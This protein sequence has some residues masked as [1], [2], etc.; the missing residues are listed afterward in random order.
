METR[1]TLTEGNIKMLMESQQSLDGHIRDDLGITDSQWKFNLETNHHLALEIEKA[2]FINECFD[3]WKYWKRKPVTME[4]ILDEAVDV[5]HFCFI[6]IN[7]DMLGK[8]GAEKTIKRQM[9]NYIKWYAG[10]NLKAEPLISTHPHIFMLNY[11]NENNASP[12]Q[13][14][15]KT[16]MILNR[17]GFLNEHVIAQ[18]EIKNGVNHERIEQGY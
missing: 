12:I 4:K 2:E 9:D 15:A 5:I 11:L 10:D 8:P 3:A 17:Y 13:I 7:K 6:L 18:Y 1:I 16:L 14:L